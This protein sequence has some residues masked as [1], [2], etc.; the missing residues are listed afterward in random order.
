MIKRI[1]GEQAAFH[2]LTENTSYLIRITE[3]GHPSHLYYGRKIDAENESDLAPLIER[4]EFEI[5]NTVVYSEEHPTVM[6]EDMCLEMS[7]LGHGD[8]REPFIELIKPN[9]SRSCDFLF[10]SAQ[11][12]DKLPRLEGLPTSYD[13]NGKGEH[14]CLTLKDGKLVLELNYYVYPD[15]DI[16]TRTARLINNGSE[17]IELL[18]LLSLQLDLFGAGWAVTNFR[19]AW[20]REMNKYTIPLPAGKIVNESRTGCS[21]NRANPFFMLHSADATESWGDV[22][23][24]NL[25]YSGS[26]YSA[27]EVNAYD[28]TRVVC[29]IQPQGFQF[30]LNSGDVFETPEAVMTYSPLGFTGQSVN[31]HRFVK[32]HIVRGEWKNKERPVLLNSW[33][34]SYF[35]ISER[36]LVSLAKAAKDLGIELLVM[37]DGWFGERSDDRRSLGDWDEN[38]KKLPGGLKSLCDKINNLGLDFGIWVEPE[39]VNVQS[40]LYDAHP[41]WAMAVPGQLH[42]EGRHQRFLD[43]CNPEVVDFLIEKMSAVFRSANISYVKWDMNRVFSDVYSPY[44]PYE[45]QGEVAHRYVLG[46]YRIMGALC[47]RFPHILFEGC[48]SGGNRFDL[49]IL[50][51]FPQ[52]WGSDNTDALCRANIQEGYSYGYPLSCVGSHVSASPNH[53]T[54]RST[55]LET[56]FNV[57]AFGALG[58]E[59]DVKDMNKESK[60]NTK[61]QI[62][63]YTEWRKV[64][65]MGQFYRGRTGNLHEWTVVSPDK[66]R[67]VG[68]IFQELT[69]PNTQA[70]H[71]RAQGLDPKRTYRFYNISGRVNVKLFGSL[72]NT[73]API[74][75]KQD[76]MLHDIIARVVKMGDEKEDFTLKGSVLMQNGVRLSPSFSGSGYNEKVRLFPDFAS[77]MY[78]MIADDK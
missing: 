20:T 41:D 78:F 50:A 24:F 33:E 72:I 43:L 70:E 40:K 56:R 49:G 54:L 15:C 22:Y 16:I 14:L 4:R 13:E 66:S 51:Y 64:F 37:D 55:P 12:D 45:R 1:S 69:K 67:A 9:G 48:A 76:S 25:I 35:N 6:L 44:L 42:S 53:Q 46:L 30:T 75:V 2:L 61:A 17:K 71:Y 38:P 3:S 68:M 8:V 23:G 73:M 57:A 11:I 60:E 63:L 34:A 18:R 19:G 65:Q 26:H 27:V 36:S 77:R 32:N 74:H 62:L 58:Y 47:E 21:S 39:M 29:G 10:D 52:I 28:K 31:M 7:S 5:G 59:L